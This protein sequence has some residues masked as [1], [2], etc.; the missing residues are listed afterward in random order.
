MRIT[1][2][3]KNLEYWMRTEGDREVLIED[4]TG[5]PPRML[6]VS[7][8]CQWGGDGYG[9]DPILIVGHDELED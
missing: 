4:F 6:K 1:E 2:L 7:S 5:L 3:I 8:V 9:D